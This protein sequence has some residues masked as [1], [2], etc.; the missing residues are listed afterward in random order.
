MAFDRANFATT[1]LGQGSNAP[2]VC[3]HR[4]AASTKAEIATSGYFN[5][6][7]DQLELGDF[8][9]AAGSDGSMTIAVTSAS[10]AA[11]VTTEEATLA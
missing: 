9:L 8:I 2:K 1:G 3:T 5:T 11:V 7:T 4:D 10:G 6:V